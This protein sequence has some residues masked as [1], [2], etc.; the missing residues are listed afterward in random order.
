MENA[1]TIFNKVKAI[2]A[3]VMNVEADEISEET[4]FTEDLSADSLDLAE[5]VMEIE[6]EFLITIDEDSLEN[7]KTVKDAVEA[8]GDAI[9]K[10]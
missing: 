3:D 7:I 6:E 10:E 1:N 2:I 5:I 4:S 8:I 9:D